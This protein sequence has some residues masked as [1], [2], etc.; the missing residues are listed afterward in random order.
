[1]VGQP[2]GVPVQAML[3]AMLSKAAP[4]VSQPF[5]SLDQAA[6]Q[7]LLVRPC[8]LQQP[9]ACTDT[10]ALDSHGIWRLTAWTDPDRGLQGLKSEMAGFCR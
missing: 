7:V 1:M 8:R 3:S 9:A 6:Q 4:H 10:D 2:D 5:S